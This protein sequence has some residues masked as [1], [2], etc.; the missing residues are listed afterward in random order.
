MD[1]EYFSTAEKLRELALSQYNCAEFKSLFENGE[2]ISLSYWHS[3]EDIKNWK[4]N[5]LHRKAQLLGK[6]KWYKSYKVEV[7]QMISAAGQ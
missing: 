3:L 7:T 5:N 6:S 1:P 4:A 2:E